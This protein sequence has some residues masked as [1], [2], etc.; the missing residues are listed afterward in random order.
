MIGGLGE[1]ISDHL[2]RRD[3][4]DIYFS[5]FGLFSNKFHLDVKVFCLR[6]GSKVFDLIKQP[7]VVNMI[8]RWSRGFFPQFFDQV[9]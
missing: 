9:A 1:R 4:F 5:Q 3:G 2:S 8:Y 6:V 7:F